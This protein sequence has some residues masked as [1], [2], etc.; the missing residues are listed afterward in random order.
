[1][2]FGRL[3]VGAFV[4]QIGLPALGDREVSLL[5]LRSTAGVAWAL[6]GDAWVLAAGL[7]TLA[8]DLTTASGEVV[9]AF[10][11][12]A[13]ANI[14]YRPPGQRLRLGLSMRLPQ[15]A[16]IQGGGQGGIPEAIIE[17][18]RFALGGAWWIGEGQLNQPIP[19][20][21]AYEGRPPAVDGMLLTVDLVLVLPRKL[22]GRDAGG[23][24]AFFEGRTQPV[25]PRPTLSLRVGTE[26]E[27]VADH[28]RMR[29]GI[30][31]EPSRFA[32]ISPRL[33][34]S[35]GIDVRLF[36]VYG[37]S[38]RGSLAFDL[39]AGYSISSLSLGFW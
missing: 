9:G 12:G 28:V 34:L 6:P 7:H 15:A 24:E 33:H 25:N 16:R 13:G 18:W 20:S 1:L 8:N 17:P 23:L 11:L 22:G 21:D 32:G 26:T 35:G 5:V 4:D 10:A 3:G 30:W 2:R 37:V 36:T 38:I 27:P 31:L 19:D 29:G 14:L 39:A